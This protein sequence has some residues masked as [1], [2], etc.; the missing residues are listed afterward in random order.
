MVSSITAAA[1]GLILATFS[2]EAQLTC[3]LCRD[4][5]AIG[6][7][8]QVVTIPGIP[9]PLTCAAIPAL[10]PTFLPN[11]TPDQCELVLAVGVL[12][13]CPQRPDSCELCLDGGTITLPDRLADPDLLAALFPNS[14]DL[15]PGAVPNCLLMDAFLR[16]NSDDS[17]ICGFARVMSRSFCGC[18]EIEPEEIPEDAANCTLCPDGRDLKDPSSLLAFADLPLGTCENL[19]KVSTGVAKE[20]TKVCAGIREY[21]AEGGCECEAPA[22]S[23]PIGA[24]CFPGDS[25]IQVSL[26]GATKPLDQ[27]KI[28]DL[29]RTGSSTMEQVYSF[30][31]NQKQVVAEYL[32]ITTKASTL[33][34]SSDHMVFTASGSAI[35]AANAKIGDSLIVVLEGKETVAPI[36]QIRAI[37]ANGAFAP[38]TKSG[39]ILVDGFVASN[40]V[41]LN[42]KST[43]LGFLDMQW[44][45]HVFKAPHRLAYFML[46]VTNETYTSEGLS[47]WIALPLRVGKWMM[48]ES[49][50]LVTIAILG[51]VLALA[52]VAKFIEDCAGGRPE[53]LPW[54]VL[55]TCVIMIRRIA[56]R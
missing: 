40:Y 1:I 25:T 11:P 20:G 55:L 13:D 28:G 56:K 53:V 35:P 39:K 4:D 47:N 14:T 36:Q 29:V 27:I 5:A 10:L 33:R 46:G 19:E 52:S 54:L 45:A 49:N 2:A 7:P 38:M 42:G 18:S 30:G 48:H 32:E 26:E 50:V 34:L 15:A 12:C 41:S 43:L 23:T 31:H 17:Q 8:N 6:D 21:S 51:P 24:I 3:P 37:Q 22:T 16:A 44:V 9:I